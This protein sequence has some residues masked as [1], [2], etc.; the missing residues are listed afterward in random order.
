M[1]S[2]Q[3]THVLLWSWSAEPGDG[4]GESSCVT[5]VIESS[6]CRL[7]STSCR[8]VITSVSS[9]V[10]IELS[11]STLGALVAAVSFSS[12]RACRGRS[13]PRGASGQAG[14]GVKLLLTG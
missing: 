2:G 14:S 11:V 1:T 6:E 4:L 9:R 13:G 10:S 3:S 8:S 12:V 5:D 7:E